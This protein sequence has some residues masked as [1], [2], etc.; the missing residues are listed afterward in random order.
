MSLSDEKRTAEIGV[1]GMRTASLKAPKIGTIARLRESSKQVGFSARE[2]EANTC[3][4][5]VEVA[6]SL[7]KLILPRARPHR[8]RVFYCTFH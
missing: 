7:P 8:V 4:R 1:R 6:R 2:F 5:A 3:R